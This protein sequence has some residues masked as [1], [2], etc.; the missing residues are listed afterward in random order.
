MCSSRSFPSCLAPDLLKCSHENVR[1]YRPCVNDLLPKSL[2]NVMS[3]KRTGR[4]PNAPPGP[5]DLRGAVVACVRPRGRTGRRGGFEA[6]LGPVF[7]TAV[8]R[9]ANG[10]T[11]SS[12]L[13]RV[14]LA[15]LG[16][17]WRYP[18]QHRLHAQDL[19]AASVVSV[20]AGPSPSRESWGYQQDVFQTQATENWPGFVCNGIRNRPRAP[21]TTSVVCSQYRRPPVQPICNPDV[22]GN[23]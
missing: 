23:R 9:A 2:K 6:R 13:L 4:V 15:D 3:E 19:Q 14:E 10:P 12:R 1:V 11:R 18:Y 7:G 5:L 17:E 8:A 20:E 22:H 16:I 21:L